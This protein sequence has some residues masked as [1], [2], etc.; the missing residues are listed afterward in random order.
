LFA[1][2]ALQFPI[3]DSEVITAPTGWTSNSDIQAS[4]GTQGLTQ[5]TYYKVVAAGD[6]GTTATWS[7]TTAAASSGGI[8]DISNVNTMNP[9]DLNEELD[10]THTTIQGGNYETSGANELVLFAYSITGTNTI[11]LPAGVTSI[12]QVNASGTP[13]TALAYLVQAT[14]SFVGTFNATAATA[15]PNAGLTTGIFS[16]N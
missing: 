16:G 2:I 10:G 5:L 7:Y 6:P 12:Y 9:V 15:G 13:A 11:T 3:Q 8:T 1:T 4:N 14:P